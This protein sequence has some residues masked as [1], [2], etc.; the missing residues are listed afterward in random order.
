MIYPF[1][2]ISSDAE[3]RYGNYDESRR[4]HYQE[5]GTYFLGG[6][7]GESLRTRACFLVRWFR[8]S[9][10]AQDHAVHALELIQRHLRAVL[11][12][13]QLARRRA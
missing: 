7:Y 12:L 11:R 6:E 3:H 9:I 5:R 4:L 8:R 2:G 13:D 10:R 1:G